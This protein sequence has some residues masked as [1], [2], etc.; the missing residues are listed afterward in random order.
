MKKFEQADNATASDAEDVLGKF[1]VA[2]KKVRKDTQSINGSTQNVVTAYVAASTKLA[3]LRW[4]RKAL[5]D[6]EKYVAS[7]LLQR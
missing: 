3:Y 2:D 4:I 5:D 7:E 1:R 6:E